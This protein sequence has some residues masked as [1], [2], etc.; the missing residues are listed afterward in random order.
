VPH[1]IATAAAARA[2]LKVSSPK[3]KDV[4]SSSKIVGGASSSNPTVGAKKAFESVKKHLVPMIGAMAGA[5]L[6]ESQESSLHGLIARD[7]THATAS[8]LEPHGQSS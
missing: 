4:A 3:S 2:M 8:R 5:F 6:E 1:A 7:L